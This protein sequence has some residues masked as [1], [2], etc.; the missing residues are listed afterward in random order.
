MPP[1]SI[2][3]SAPSR[4]H[5]GMFAFGQS[6]ARQFGG[7]G[8]MVDRPGL[9]VRITHADRLEVRG[10][11]ARRATAVLKRIAALDGAQNPPRVDVEILSAPPEHIGLGT[12][13]Q[14]TL[15]IWTGL[16]TLERGQSLDSAALAERAQR[17]ERSA[18]GTHG[19][20]HGGLLVESGKHEGARLS[21]LVSRAKLNEEW[22]FVLVRPKNERGLSGETERATFAEL[23]PIPQDLTSQLCRELVMHLLPAAVESNFEEFSES[24]YRYGHQAG[25]CFA[26]KQAGAFA[27]E[28]L[29]RWV[30]AIRA[31][32][33]RGVGQSSWGPTL[34]ALLPDAAAAEDFRARLPAAIDS[35]D[36]EIVI[37]APN[38]QGARLEL[39][40][41]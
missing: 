18:I 40:E 37:A 23:P 14:L 24:L 27:S 3:I 17:G 2:L 28:R 11:L 13:T 4:L 10:P 7:V 25:M 12:G 36:V 9:A 41:S 22:R 39:F 6:G 30:E 35:G 31:L 29:T 26:P 32:G 16:L 19:F 33:V 15:A 5:F 20:C 8:A 1:R 21:P 38:N 34:F